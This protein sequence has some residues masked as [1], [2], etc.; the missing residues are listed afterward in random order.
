MA[1]N[2]FLDKKNMFVFS[3][4]EAMSSWGQVNTKRQLQ[5]Q[6]KID[7]YVWIDEQKDRQ[8]DRWQICVKV[9]IGR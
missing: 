9:Q 5:K 3:F 1:R 6:I 8:I 2:I 7:K 4:S